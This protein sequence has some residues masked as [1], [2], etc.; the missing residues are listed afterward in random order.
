MNASLLPKRYNA[1][2]MS[3]F[4]LLLLYGNVLQASPACPIISQSFQPSV[5][6]A[7]SDASAT[8]WTLDRSAV[9]G[10]T[11]FA[12]QSHRLKA[13]N[14]G[15]IGIWTSKEFTITGYTAPQA[16]VKITS[17]GPLA[18]TDYVQVYYKLNGGA[19]VLIDSR[20][21]NFGTLIFTSPVLTNG[22]K[23]QLVVKI[24]NA[25]HNTQQPSIYYVEQYNVFQTNGPCTPGN[26]SI[27]VTAAASNSG[28]LTCASNSV[29]LSATSATS[30][31]SY[32]WKGPNNWSSNAATPTVSAA[33]A[34]SLTVTAATTPVTWG[35]A[36]INVITNTTAPAGV[37]SSNNGPL[38]CTKTTVTLSGAS[39]TTGTT[40]KWSGP[41]SFNATGANVSA[42]AAGNYTLTATHPTTGCTTTSTTTVVQNAAAPA[43]IT[44]ASIPANATLT[45]IRNF[46]DLSATSSTAG[47]FYSWSGPNINTSPSTS[48]AA[49]VLAPGLYTVTVSNPANGCTATAHVT[50][51]QD[52]HFAGNVAITPNPV[53]LTC[54][55]PTS[56]L[57]GSSSTAG[58]SYSWS[59]PNGFTAAGVNAVA[60]TPGAY[61]LTVVNNVNGCVSTTTAQVD[62][63]VHQPTGVTASNNGPLSC[64]RPSVLLTGSAATGGDNFSWTGPNGFMSSIPTAAVSVPGTYS[65]TVT[66]QVSGCSSTAN[67]VVSQSTTAPAGLSVSSSTGS[68]QL[69]CTSNS[70][71]LTASAS[72]LNTSYSWSGP[73]GF[74]AAGADATVTSPGSYTVTATESTGGCTS[75]LTIQVTQNIAPPA[76][77]V[78]TSVPSNALLN[79]TQGNVVLTGS[80]ATSGAAYSWS[81]PEGFSAAAAIATAVTPGSY[82]LTVTDPSNGCTTMATAT[83]TQDLTPPASVTATP[84]NQLTCAQNMVT[85]TGNSSTTGATYSW[86]G[87]GAFS[88]NLRIT[89]TTTAGAYILTVTNPATGCIATKLITVQQNTNPPANVTIAP[90]DMLTCDV[91]SVDLAGS[92][93]TP[94]V[95]YIWSGPDDFSDVAPVTTVTAPGE[96]TLTVTNP[97]NGCSSTAQVTVEQDLSACE[98]LARAATKGTTA[99]FVYKIYPNPASSQT[100]IDLSSPNSAHLEVAIYSS[101]GLR[102]KLVFD[103]AIEARQSYKLSVDVSRMAA[104]LHFYLIKVDGKLYSSKLLLSPGH[105]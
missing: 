35:T 57:T 94:N 8:G 34:Y 72:T 105:P 14:L 74:S 25:V 82:V 76:D 17:E 29:I 3:F 71:V 21:G 11:Y 61:V 96:Y 7:I 42:A 23:V 81:G 22:T 63:N 102:E 10:A 27:T 45:C 77:V 68:T 18:G 19:L 58:V 90:P 47:V 44:T 104:G 13:A 41:N 24:F 52:Q 38:T 78:T 28:M 88:S 83:V 92:S 6:G 36:G 48:S 33:G 40:F 9:T 75:S 56:N 39:S 32:F 54:I 53:L 12:V 85:L 31:L 55:N 80:S 67:T 2:V 98:T 46:I 97:N 79:C 103:G 37:T 51:L 60:N 64:N 16:S 26:P 70:T 15:G 87:P 91:T 100:F 101:T 89:T 5:D 4:L 20:T 69:T 65:L 62:Q 99:T 49:T 59:G 1:S 95:F 30:G 50:V 43:G 93:I 73:G 84:S 66:D 86:T